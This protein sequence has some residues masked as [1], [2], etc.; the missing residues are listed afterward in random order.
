MGLRGWIG[1]TEAPIS[2]VVLAALD[3]VDYKMTA[4]KHHEYQDQSVRGVHGLAWPIKPGVCVLAAYSYN[5]RD[6]ASVTSPRDPGGWN[7]FVFVEP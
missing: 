1:W 2:T 5:E 7:P 6:F 3:G 4:L